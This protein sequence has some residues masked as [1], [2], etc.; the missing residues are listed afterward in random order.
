M[1]N[2][3]K[4]YDADTHISPSAE[5]IE[6]F[7][8]KRVRE[9]VPDL[10]SYKVPIKLGLAGEIR[11]EPWKHHY[12]FSRGGEG[13]GGGA[14]RVLGEPEPRRDHQRHFQNFHG[15]RFPTDGGIEFADLRVKDMDDEGVDVQ[16][17]VPNGANGHPDP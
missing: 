2:G 4:V 11:P 6:R 14:V 8:S 9:L 16:F 5:T 15:S 10:D 7:L 12:R 13:W 3:Y 17:M 1:R